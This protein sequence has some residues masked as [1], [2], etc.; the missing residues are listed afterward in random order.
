MEAPK[1]IFDLTD[2]KWRSQVVISDPRFGTM[3]FHA[4]A[5][6]GALGDERAIQFFQDLKRNDV[7]IAPSVADV[8]RLVETAEFAIGLTDTDDANL[9]VLPGSPVVVVYPDEGSAR[10]AIDSKHGFVDRGRAQPRSRAGG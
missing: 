4:A 6:F 1:S 7:T 5:L 8:R 9:A 3:L 2:P 10:H